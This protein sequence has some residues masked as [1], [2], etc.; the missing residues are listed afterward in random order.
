[1]LNRQGLRQPT[2]FQSSCLG[3]SQQRHILPVQGNFLDAHPQAGSMLSLLR[4]KKDTE[5]WGS[6]SFPAAGTK[7][8]PAKACTCN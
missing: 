2:K 3:T 6:S 8:H 7:F 4:K 1:M 5:F